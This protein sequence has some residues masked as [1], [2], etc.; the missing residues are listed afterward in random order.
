[1]TV[2]TEAGP[3]EP[4]LEADESAPSPKPRRRRGRF[5]CFIGLLFGIAGV[6]AGWFGKLWIAFDVF[7]QFA[8]HFWLIALAFALGFVMP[9]ARVLT[10]LAII[11]IGMLVIGIIPQRNAAT[12]PAPGI[13]APAG[14]RLVRI[15][16]FNTW[17]GNAKVEA[18]AAEVERNDP[19]ILVLLEFG[20][21][22]RALL[23][24]L[25]GKYR[26]QEDCVHLEDCYMAV[27]SK[28]PIADSESH[29]VWEGPPMMRVTFGNELS[30]LTII[31]AHT[32]RFPYLRAQLAQLGHLGDLV[33]R[34]SGPRIVMGDFNATPSSRLLATFEERSGLRRLDGWL[35][36]W[37]ARLQIPQL[38]IDHIFA[39]A[40]V[41]SVEPVR[42]GKNAGSDHFPVVVRV[43][44]PTPL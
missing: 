34:L 42:I 25:R 27:F 30:G 6:L 31:G 7:A 23:D 14:T 35:P 17:M 19:D 37:P 1:M 29:A 8:N 2:E 36:T 3:R 41:K 33:R 21:E 44:I 4:E 39:S 11:I 10:A 9:R 15:M 28:Y 26:Y 24:R 40:E 32:I 13:Q 20:P 18:I 38:A 16:S 12:Y 5:T 43:A 22:K